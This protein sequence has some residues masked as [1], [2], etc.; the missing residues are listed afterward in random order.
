MVKVVKGKMGG[1]G[2]RSEYR[3]GKEVNKEQPPA[4]NLSETVRRLLQSTNAANRMPTFW[5]KI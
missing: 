5:Y 3:S 1:C 2:G 4:R